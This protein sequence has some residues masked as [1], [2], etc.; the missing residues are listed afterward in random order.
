MILGLNFLHEQEFYFPIGQLNEQRI[1]FNNDL[2]SN[3]MIDIGF[4]VPLDSNSK[5]K[6]FPPE[7]DDNFTNQYSEYSDVFY[8]GIIFFRLVTGLVLNY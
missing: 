3:L 4:I 5:S 1:F 7:Y 6:I 8:L 2:I